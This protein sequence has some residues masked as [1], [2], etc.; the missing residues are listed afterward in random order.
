MSSIIPMGTQKIVI[1]KTKTKKTKGK[2]T[3]KKLASE[4]KKLKKSDK[5]QIQWNQLTRSYNANV[6]SD[7][8]YY[9][10]DKFSSMSLIFGAGTNDTHQNKVVNYSDLIRLNFDLANGGLTETGKVNFH[11]FL[12]SLRDEI[13]SAFTPSSGALSLTSGTHYAVSQ[14]MY[15]LNPQYFKI[16][17]SKRFFLDNHGI[18]LSSSTGQTQYGTNL[19]FD[20]YKKRNQYVSTPA[21]DWYASPCPADPSKNAFVLIFN[22]NS[23]LDVEYPSMNLWHKK[24]VKTG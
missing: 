5:R 18:A 7:Y 22:D 1:N 12:V 6:Q 17:S 8:M 23:I 15:I 20:M 13:G 16:H 19:S 14:G 4:V 21:G 10:L 2:V 3:L 24:V 11:V 9:E